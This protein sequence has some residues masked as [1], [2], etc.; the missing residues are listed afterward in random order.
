M[1]GLL[2]SSA[3]VLVLLV[4]PATGGAWSSNWFQSPSGNIRCRYFPTDGIVACKTVNNGRTAVVPLRGEAYVLARLTDY[5]FPR[6]PVLTYGDY[7]SVSGRFRCDSYSY[8]MKCRSLR[9]GHGFV[10]SRSGFRTF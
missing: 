5:S 1:R 7:W 8:G 6:G 4:A 3:V 2:A 10:V 9:T